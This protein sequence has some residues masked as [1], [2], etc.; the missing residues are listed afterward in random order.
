MTAVALAE[1][2]VLG[3]ADDLV[4]LRVG[5][6]DD[7]ELR[8]R[9]VDHVALPEPADG[10]RPLVPEPAPDSAPGLH[11]LLAQFLRLCDPQDRARAA[12]R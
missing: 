8:V 9:L 6:D 3:V 1:P 7:A 2:C 10:Q 5:G 4:E 12:R 11:R